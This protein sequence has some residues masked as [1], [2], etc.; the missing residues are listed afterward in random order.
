MTFSPVQQQL[1][2]RSVV[3]GTSAVFEVAFL[4]TGGTPLVP[5]DPGSYPAVSITDSEGVI[6]DAGVATSLGGGRWRYQLMVPGDAVLSTDDNP[7]RIDWLMTTLQGRQSQLS[8]N[9]NVIDVMSL[10]PNDRA[11]TQMASLGESERLV[12]K[13]R[14]QQSEYKLVLKDMGGETCDLSSSIQYVVNSG[15]HVYYVDTPA[16]QQTG[17]Y[18]ATWTTRQSVISPTQTIVQTIVVPEQAFWFLQS[19]LRML[20]D[21]VQKKSGHVQAYSDSDI[22][23]Y[24]QRGTEIVN[25][26]TPVTHWSLGSAAATG[27]LT[28]YI[29]AA[30]A[31]YGLQ[32]QYL[33][34][35][36]LAFNFSGQTVTLDV[37]R[38]GY[39]DAAMSRLN[40]FIQQQLP[41][42]K[43]GLL[44]QSH[45]GVSAG[46]PYS[47]RHGPYM[48]KLAS[49][50]GG[51][52]SAAMI[53]LGKLGL[54]V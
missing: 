6:A 31:W 26:V 10:E 40:D 2:T 29:L 11:Y 50:R 1:I 12:V 13:F 35:G 21:K 27:P 9:F 28:T 42:V 7:W 4:D 16:W 43:K 20:I 19:S 39:Y 51:D 32:A 41:T 24:L 47:F 49:G 30:A 22:Y 54:L 14:A 46:R 8:Q 25:G 52:A 3:R 15:W 33:S 23:E 5:A 34:E 36:E 53:P 37:D 38:T 48:G 17:T 44:R 18:L 45:A